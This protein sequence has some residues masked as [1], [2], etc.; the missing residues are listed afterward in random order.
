MALPHIAQ[1]Q[2]LAGEFESLLLHYSPKSIA[3]LGCAGGNGFE[4]ISP[5]VTERVV[6]VDINPAYIK[7]TRARFSGRFDTFELYI[8][9]IQTAAVAFEPVELIYAALVFEY[10][11]IH[12]AFA[13]VRTLVKSEGILCTI[14]Q[15]VSSSTSAVSSSP[16]SSLQSLTQIMHLISPEELRTCAEEVG[17]KQISARALELRSGKSFQVQLFRAHD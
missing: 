8:G 11:D 14:A 5:N 9:D 13:R 10:V 3:V 7:E 16:F 17:F 15:L 12:T 2:M 6:G 4:R 1:A